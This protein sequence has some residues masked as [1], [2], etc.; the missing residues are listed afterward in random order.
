MAKVAASIYN[1]NSAQHG[2]AAH[3]VSGH[4][5]IGGGSAYLLTLGT[6]G[7]FWLVLHL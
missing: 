7:W 5:R 6:L 3:G 1:I 2:L 4:D